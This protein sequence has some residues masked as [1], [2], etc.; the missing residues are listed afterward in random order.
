[1]TAGQ[2]GLVFMLHG[3]TYTVFTP[4]FG[5]LNDK[6]ISG[7]SYLWFGNLLI[8]IGFTFIGPIPWLK[9]IGGHLWLTCVALGDSDLFKLINSSIVYIIFY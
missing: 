7:A 2:T 8:G 1:M 3:T 9:M 6:G 5:L 4:I